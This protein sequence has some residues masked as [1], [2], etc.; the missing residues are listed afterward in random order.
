MQLSHLPAQRIAG[1][2]SRSPEP[3][4]AP[5]GALAAHSSNANARLQSAPIAAMVEERWQAW[6][7]G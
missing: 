5:D 1:A 2:F 4:V 3:S 6:S 7:G